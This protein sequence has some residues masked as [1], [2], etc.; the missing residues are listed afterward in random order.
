MEDVTEDTNDDF[1]G[2]TTGHIPASID[3]TERDTGA[4]NLTSQLES[5]GL[6]VFL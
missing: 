6:A 5:R 1:T 3:H 2:Y 4:E